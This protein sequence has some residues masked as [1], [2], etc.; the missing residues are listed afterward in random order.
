MNFPQSS[1]PFWV[2]DT[3][4]SQYC[5]DS[6][7]YFVA[8]FTSGR[9][10]TQTTTAGDTGSK[11]YSYNKVAKD[12]LDETSAAFEGLLLAVFF[13][14]LFYFFAEQIDAFVYELTGV[15]SVGAQAVSPNAVTDFALNLITRGKYQQAQQGIKEGE[16]T[17]EK[18][19]RRLGIQVSDKGKDKSGV[20]VSSKGDSSGVSV[21]G[22]DKSGSGISVSSQNRQRRP[23]IRINKEDYD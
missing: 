11:M 9:F 2:L 20:S 10:L 6:F 22:S 4:Q 16:G 14:F 7:G 3:D 1:K 13:A 21:S 5:K 18:G 17:K 8:N 15:A 12:T 23:D 19:K